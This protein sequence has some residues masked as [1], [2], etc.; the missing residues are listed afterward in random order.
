MLL[1]NYCLLSAIFENSKAG[2]MRHNSLQSNVYSWWNPHRKTKV[3]GECQ[4]ESKPSANPW[5]HSGW[6]AR[7]ET[8]QTASAT[9][10]ALVASHRPLPWEG[11]EW[12]LPLARGVEAFA[13]G[14]GSWAIGA[15]GAD[16]L[17]SNPTACASA[18]GHDL[19]SRG[20][21][22]GE[23]CSVLNISIAR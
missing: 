11:N 16:P 18:C 8:W 6:T 5:L 20:K 10:G 12:L 17:R 2:S 15:M 21:L 14:S 1:W 4:R 7:G 22:V 3:R 13:A 9:P 23:K 19:S